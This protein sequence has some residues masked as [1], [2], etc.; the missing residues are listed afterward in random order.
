VPPELGDVYTSE[1][2]Y[3]SKRASQKIGYR[4]KRKREVPQGIYELFDYALKPKAT[5]G[6]NTCASLQGSRGKLVSTNL[7]TLSWLFFKLLHTFYRY[8]QSL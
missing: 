8:L 6:L 3:S 2:N 7:S 1:F 5:Q 4:R